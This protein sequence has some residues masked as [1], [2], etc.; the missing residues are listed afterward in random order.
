MV[1]RTAPKAA[2]VNGASR[3]GSCPSIPSINKIFG[4]QRLIILDFVLG[5][6]YNSYILL[7]PY[8]RFGC[9]IP[10]RSEQG[11]YHGVEDSISHM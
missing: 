11:V 1:F 10:T 3:A 7:G 5:K 9:T 2:G 8:T 4:E 6:A